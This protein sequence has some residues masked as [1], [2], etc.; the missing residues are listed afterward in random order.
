IIKT[1]FNAKTLEPSKRYVDG[2]KVE[3][4]YAIIP[5]KTIPGESTIKGLS[6]Q[7][8]NI[9]HEVIATTLGMFHEDYI[10]EET[11]IMTHV[12]DF[13][14]KTNRKVEKDKGWKNL[15]P[16]KEE[17]KEEKEV[18]PT[19]EQNEKVKSDIGIKEGKT[20][21]PKP[22]TEGQLINMMKTCGSKVEN[23][24]DVEI[25]KEVEGLGTEATRSN[26]IENIKQREYIEVKKKI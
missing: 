26:I 9:Y 25:L 2:S 20:K 6:E 5:T 10:Y 23:D 18:L 8:K 4:H 11:T 7:E 21:P 3:E 24:E 1:E 17:K 13:L 14:I 22:Y 16:K 12:N 19:V 15:F